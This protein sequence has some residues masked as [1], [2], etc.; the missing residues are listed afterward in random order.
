M[1]E[2]PKYLRVEVPL[3]IVWRARQVTLLAHKM[4]K[5]YSFSMTTS[6]FWMALGWLEMAWKILVLAAK[7]LYEPLE[8]GGIYKVSVHIG[9]D[10]RK[11]D[12]DGDPIG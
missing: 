3:S 12:E 9:D 7:A 2:L 6:R 5:A 8:N 1:S 4:E 11:Q 10:A